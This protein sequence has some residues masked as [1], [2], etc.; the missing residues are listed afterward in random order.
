[1]AAGVNDRVW[2]SADS[3]CPFAGNVGRKLER[4]CFVPERAHG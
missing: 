1:M 3:S 4:R 2:H